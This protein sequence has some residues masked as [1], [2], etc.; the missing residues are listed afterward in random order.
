MTLEEILTFNF[1]K[2]TYDGIVEIYPQ[3]LLIQWC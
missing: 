1:V 2:Q 3:K